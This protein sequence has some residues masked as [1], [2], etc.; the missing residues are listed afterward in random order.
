MMKVIVAS[1]RDVYPNLMEQIWR[2]RHRQ[3][4]ERLGWR[5]LASNDKRERDRFDTNDAIHLCITNGKS[6]IGYSRLLR[7][8]EPHLLSDVYPEIMQGHS[9]PRATDIYEWTRCI[10]DEKAGKLG[11]VQVSHILITGV[12]EF[13]LTAGIRGLIVETHPKIVTWMHETGYKV[14][15]LATPQMINEVPVVPV[16]IAATHM[17]LVR[18]HALFGIKSSVLDIDDGLLNPVTR[19]GVLLPLAHLSRPVG[20]N[21]MDLPDV[22]FE[23][24]R[25]STRSQ[26]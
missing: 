19:A 3:F 9:W 6:V 1:N 16:Y 15:P 7:T 22:D 11:D 8:S 14:Q 13:C 21:A 17:A 23:A 10:S 18:H 12:L 26:S 24:M 2:F 20:G 5:E 4:V 25:E